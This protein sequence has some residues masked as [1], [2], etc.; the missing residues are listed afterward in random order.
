MYR[1]NLS[2]I[3]GELQYEGNKK[4]NVLVC[5]IDH[6]DALQ[7]SEFIEDSF[8]V[9]NVSVIDLVDDADVIIDEKPADVISIDSDQ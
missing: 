8:S 2:N 7:N 1:R 4:G 3:T 5:R 6:C 9:D